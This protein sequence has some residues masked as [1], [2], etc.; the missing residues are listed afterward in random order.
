MNTR[1]NLAHLAAGFVGWFVVNGLL[2]WPNLVI[3]SSAGIICPVPNLV[4]LLAVGRARP[5]VGWGIGLA[6]VVNLLAWLGAAWLFRFDDPMVALVDGLAALPILLP[7]L[8]GY[9]FAR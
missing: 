9:D 5:W 6:Y 2:W 4:V 8:L 1:V 7:P 3:G